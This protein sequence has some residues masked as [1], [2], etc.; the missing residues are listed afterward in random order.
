MVK[1]I[2]VQFIR[3]LI[4]IIFC[5]EINDAY[6][7]VSNL[8]EKVSDRRIDL[9]QHV[10]KI[11]TDSN[12]LFTEVYNSAK[13]FQVN[14]KAELKQEYTKSAL[15]V[16][17]TLYNDT[18]KE[19]KRYLYLDSTLS[20]KL[21]L[22]V[23]N[24]NGTLV[25]QEQNGNSVSYAFRKVKSLVP[26]FYLSILPNEKLTYY[27]K[28]TSKHRLDTK[29]F[30]ADEETF[31]KEDDSKKLFLYFY[32]GAVLAIAL[33]NLLIWFFTKDIIYLLYFFLCVGISSLVLNLNGALDYFF[34]PKNFNFSK[35]VLLS[36]A[37]AIL[38]TSI[39]SLNFLKIKHNLPTALRYYKFAFIFILLHISIVFT[40]FFTKYSNILGIT[41]DLT[42]ALTLL[43][44]LVTTLL[45]LKK[46]VIMAKFYLGSF[47]FI[48]IGAGIWFSMNLGLL[49][50][51]IFTKN[52]LLIGNLLEV[53]I[54]ALGLAYKIAYIDKI[55]DKV[56]QESVL[57]QKFLRLSRVLSHDI[58]NSLFVITGFSRKIKRDPNLVNKIETWEKIDRAS[59]NISNILHNVRAELIENEKSPINLS[60][61]N[62]YKTIE[63]SRFIFQDKLS[64]KSISLEN[65]ID[66]AFEVYSEPT[67]LLNH[68]INN[69]MSNSIKFSYENSKILF[70]SYET[71]STKSIVVSDSGIGISKE[72][73]NNFL[74]YK[75]I[76]TTPGTSGEEGTGNGLRLISNYMGRFGGHIEI[77][78]QE[79][80]EKTNSSGTKITLTFPSLS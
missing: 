64:E 48:F 37:L 55:N 19:L 66:P 75:S 7:Y 53:I 13:K 16:K 38:F 77:E 26:A 70:S 31:K 17:F 76:N 60:D 74:R 11:Q 21:E 44:I 6:G 40:P 58:S 67:I 34:M 12:V 52:S 15:W 68:I 25:H 78:S 27:I 54:I 32:F 39:F 8:S 69:L 30:L 22:F 46:K 49:P 45:C 24:D 57:H 29:I 72:N 4:S 1:F 51:N 33:Y 41:I 65:N 9:T 50:V 3:L 14:N 61:V 2:H 18:D 23:I 56:K 59:Q 36:S 5:V 79:K 63:D 47:I 20:G 71:N 80:H 35:Y 10:E 28:R 62:V 42:L 43:L 73:I